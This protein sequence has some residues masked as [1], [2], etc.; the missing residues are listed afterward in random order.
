MKNSEP[1]KISKKPYP[2][3]HCGNRAP[4]YVLSEIVERY[5]NDES[6]ALNTCYFVFRC[7]SCG[8]VNVVSEHNFIDREYL[9]IRFPDLVTTNSDEY[10]EYEYAVESAKYIQEF[11]LYP[12]DRRTFQHVPAQVERSY[13]T[14][15]KLLRVEPLACAVFIGRT[16]EFLC[17]ERK[18]AGKTLEKMLLDLKNRGEIPDRIL[19]IASSLRFFR[20]IGAHADNEMNV[21]RRDAETLIALCEAILEY[22]YEAPAVLKAAQDKADALKTG[23]EV[24]T[25]INTRLNPKRDILLDEPELND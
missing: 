19:E 8:G 6:D 4:M 11:R 18:A 24:K 2:C 13:R 22:V 5:D 23:R 21:S 9:E 7:S 14:A 1:P 16:L 3:G 20:N 25:T 10:Q 17:K 15:L 12:S